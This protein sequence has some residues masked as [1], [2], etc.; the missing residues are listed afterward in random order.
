MSIMLENVT[1]F[2]NA[3][4]LLGQYLCFSMIIN[5]DINSQMKKK[6]LHFK[7]GEL[8]VWYPQHKWKISMMKLYHQEL[9]QD[10]HTYYHRK[11][12]VVRKVQIRISPALTI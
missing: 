2:H 3:I 6:K 8:L 5:R 4:V 1:Q 12:D 9:F 10:I 7:V 11:L